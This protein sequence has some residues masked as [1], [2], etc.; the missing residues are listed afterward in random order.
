MELRREQVVDVARGMTLIGV[1]PPAR[2]SYARVPSI[3]PDLLVQFAVTLATPDECGKLRRQQPTI[4]SMEALAPR[5]FWRQSVE[6][7]L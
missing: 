4:E 1:V 5:R 7:R 3:F 6:L 2:I